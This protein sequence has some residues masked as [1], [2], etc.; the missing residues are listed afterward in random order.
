MQASL[1]LCGGGCNCVLF[2]YCMGSRVGMWSG[3]FQRILETFLLSLSSSAELNATLDRCVEKERESVCCLGVREVG[4]G[5]RASIYPKM[6]VVLSF[7]QLLQLT[8]TDL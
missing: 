5:G 3:V 1:C 2:I 6:F 7:S 4:G 8:G